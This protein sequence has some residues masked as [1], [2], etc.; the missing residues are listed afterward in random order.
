MDRIAFEQTEPA[1]EP[2]PTHP[3]AKGDRVDRFE[4]ES[5]LGAGGM[6][7]VYAARDPRLGRVV[8]IK[9]VSSHRKYAAAR[10]RLLEEARIMAKIS[11]PGVVPVFEV[12]ELADD[13]FIAMEHLPAGTLATWLRTRKHTWR[14]VATVLVAAGRGLA[15]A[16]AAGVV[17][18][19]FKPE[20]ILMTADGAPRVSDFGLAR[21]DA[22]VVD[23]GSPK[24]AG[25]TTVAGT[26]AYMAPEQHLGRTSDARSDQ[27]SFC[28]TTWEALYGERPFRPADVRDA[29]TA[30]ALAAAVTA[31]RL[32]APPRTANVPIV[33]ERALRR[34]LAV[35]P[36][37][38]WP[39]M[40]T[41]LDVLE[42]AVRP[43]SRHVA[44]TTAVAAT[45]LA[46]TAYGLHASRTR[47]EP[48]L[49][50]YREGRALWAGGSTVG[51]R[52]AFA[53]I[54]DARPDHAGAHLWAALLAEL[55]T[56]A[57]AHF[58]KAR[59]HRESLSASDE[60][61]L[62]ASEPG[63]RPMP[64]LEAWER[65]LDRAAKARSDDATLYHW[66]GR[67]R[68]RRGDLVG[69]DA[70]FREA[71]LLDPML[72]PT[73][74]AARAQLALDQRRRDD[75]RRFADA[76][77]ARAGDATDCLAVRVSL[78]GLDG[79]CA[80]METDIHAWIAADP[81]DARAYDALAMALDA[82]DAPFVAVREAFAAKWQKS[83]AE[84]RASE[85]WLDEVLLD[86]ARGDFD[87]AVERASARRA[88]IGPSAS[89]L[90]QFDAAWL[91]VAAMREAG[92]R[93]P[94]ADLA[95]DYLARAAAYVPET[96]REVALLLLFA[97]VAHELCEMPDDVYRAERTRLLALAE[98]ARRNAGNLDDPYLRLLPWIV[99]YAAGTRTSSEAN[100]ALVALPA[101]GSIPAAGISPTDTDLVFGVVYLAAGMPARAR[102]Y[103]D[104]VARTCFRLKNPIAWVFGVVNRAHMLAE[105]GERDAARGELQRVIDR[106]G[107]AR[108]R[109][110]H[111][112]EAASMLAT[113]GRR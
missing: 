64:D 87:S 99:G 49:A 12:G 15:A 1:G 21:T 45:A 96:P 75:A 47:T 88:A 34:G 97:V 83:P 2:S 59:V 14:E 71:E 19:D 44:I 73:A 42:R 110:V 91:Q 46:I 33:V 43:R 61:L 55:P 86:L 25:R 101:Y 7:I 67:V 36:D 90:A 54:I 10:A 100:E 77:L 79:E 102:P 30:A 4:V 81:D 93:K 48:E 76:C 24:S 70:A 106:W 11:H 111:A 41:L 68:G 104:G 78:R 60:A 29:P 89:L 94:A 63:L 37:A 58:A 108:P 56:E 109:S 5:I 85:Q 65:A 50:D 31:G 57:R 16:H 17:H 74:A 9:V 40:A 112:D 38:R 18:R 13:I 92:E 26:P 23:A 72:G 39:T 98:T 52:R 66:L 28:V 82:R 69:A 113:L 105:L 53:R 51:A 95:K 6:G 22:A 80:A 35:D 103:L 3:L 32:V 8:A 20:N 107:R 62:D 84:A 27:F